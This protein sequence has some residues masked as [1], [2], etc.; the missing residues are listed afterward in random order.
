MTAVPIENTH[1]SKDMAAYGLDGIFSFQI[2]LADTSVPTDQTVTG[3]FRTLA[4]VGQLLTTQEQ[5]FYSPGN[6]A[7]DQ[8]HW[9][10]YSE[11]R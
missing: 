8:S 4:P 9:R 3:G 5:A 10:C 1:I 7:A 2:N 6:A 11:S